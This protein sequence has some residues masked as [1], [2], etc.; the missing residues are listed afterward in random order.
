MLC[1]LLPIIKVSCERNLGV[2]VLYHCQPSTLDEETEQHANLLLQPINS[3]LKT[4]P[5]CKSLLATI[6]PTYQTDQVNVSHRIS[7]D[8]FNSKLIHV[9]GFGRGAARQLSGLPRGCWKMMSLSC[10][11]WPKGIPSDNL[12]SQMLPNTGKCFL[13]LQ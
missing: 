7:C 10:P 12:T 13:K 2:F 3:A 9:S 4:L 1:R 6:P 8:G 11:L 5:S